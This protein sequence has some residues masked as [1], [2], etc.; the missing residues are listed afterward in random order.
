VS[1]WVDDETKTRGYTEPQNVPV[2]VLLWVLSC[3]SHRKSVLRSINV[4]I[5]SEQIKIP[6]GKSSVACHLIDSRSVYKVLWTKRIHV[7]SNCSY[8]VPAIDSQQTS[9]NRAQTAW[10]KEYRQQTSG[11]VFCH[12]VSTTRA[13]GNQLST[14]RDTGT[15]YQQQEEGKAMYKLRMMIKA[16]HTYFISPRPI[17]TKNDTKLIRSSKEKKYTE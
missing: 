13:Q 14:L 16:G 2:V 4:H 11:H 8:L 12:P 6:R 17:C 5:M 1:N 15:T 9:Y 10:P 3:P 7:H